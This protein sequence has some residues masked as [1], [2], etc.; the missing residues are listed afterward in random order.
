MASSSSFVSFSTI[1][2]HP[3]HPSPFV[4]PFSPVPLLHDLLLIYFLFFLILKFS[5]FFSL[6]PLFILSLPP[7]LP[8]FFLSCGVSFI[9]FCSSLL[10]RRLPTFFF[11]CGVSVTF[12]CT[13]LPTFFPF[14]LPALHLLLLRFFFFF[15]FSIGLTFPKSYRSFRPFFLRQPCQRDSLC[16]G[17]AELHRAGYRSFHST[18]RLINLHHHHLY[19]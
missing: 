9:L 16:V 5:I 2:V 10:P 19:G 7:R 14:L 3:S 12:S 18:Q 8:K 11:I 6:S 1:F 15:V 13:S 4:H 17:G